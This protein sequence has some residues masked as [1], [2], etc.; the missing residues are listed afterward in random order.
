MQLPV[1]TCMAVIVYMYMCHTDM[2]ASV[3]IYSYHRLHVWLPVLTCNCETKRLKQVALTRQARAKNRQG[4]EARARSQHQPSVGITN[5]A[6]S[7][8]ALLPTAQKNCAAKTHRLHSLVTKIKQSSYHD[9]ST[10]FNSFFKR[11]AKT[12]RHLVHMN[13]TQIDKFRNRK[14]IHST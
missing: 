7:T 9:R 1:T 4:S 3:Y 13:L 11:V 2:V 6:T 5:T 12:S 8:T 14:S 10:S